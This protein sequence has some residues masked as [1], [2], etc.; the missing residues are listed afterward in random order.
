MQRV[1]I[2]LW[3]G[4]ALIVD[5]NNSMKKNH[6]P[7][8]LSTNGTLL[9]QRP[10][11]KAWNTNFISSCMMPSGDK[12]GKALTSGNLN[13]AKTHTRDFQRQFYGLS[14]VALEC[15]KPSFSIFSILST[16]VYDREPPKLNNTQ[17]YRRIA[18]VCSRI[19][20]F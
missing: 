6:K 12:L 4:W 1:R 15:L 14:A 9:L 18:P 5:H 10:S 19:T 7:P 16:F 3:T 2:P 8:F 13:G 20:T 17:T 11:T